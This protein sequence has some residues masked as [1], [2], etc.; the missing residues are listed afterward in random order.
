MLTTLEQYIDNYFF[1]EK[2]NEE[3]DTGELGGQ[4][5]RLYAPHKVKYTNKSPDGP[6][7]PYCAEKFLIRRV[8]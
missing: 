8:K 5:V 4:F 7:L 3:G 2:L 6:P 1:Y